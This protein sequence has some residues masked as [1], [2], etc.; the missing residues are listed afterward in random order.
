MTLWVG[1]KSPKQK[2]REAGIISY[3]GRY[4]LMWVNF[5][6]TSIDSIAG[7]I[8]RSLSFPD[9]TKGHGFSEEIH[10][11]SLEE[12]LCRKAVGEAGE[13]AALSAIDGGSCTILRTPTMAIVL[14][15]VYC[16]CFRGMDK[17]DYVQR[18]SFLSK[19]EIATKGSKVFFDTQ[20]LPQEGELNIGALQIDSEDPD[21][22]VGRARGDLGRAISMARRFCEWGFV[23][24]AVQS[25]ASY[26]LMDGSLQTGFP[27]ESE[28]ANAIYKDA[29][30]AG[31]KLCGLSK[32]TTIFTVEGFP[33]SGFANELARKRE[34]GKWLIS[35]GKNDEWTHR[36]EVY[37][38]KLH[39][40]ADRPYRLDVF[41][42]VTKT[43]LEGLVC[44]LQSNSKYFAFP[45]Y[46]YA[47]IDAHN[48][49]RVREE[50][51][52]HIRDKILDRL[53][54]EDARKLEQVERALA[55][56][57]ILDELG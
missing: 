20:I 30:S 56:H 8:K 50:E 7:I 2:K 54:L 4:Y 41:E 43:E 52:M 21:F 16:N 17:G 11:G 55:G 27:G 37:I 25:G 9:R 15:R 47:L 48:Y 39:E 10:D 38:V 33:V 51:A 45:G 42:G 14:N 40:G 44:A 53:D 46:P 28:L 22:K 19:T 34:L 36:A 24:R 57:D 13:V 1:C 23:R 49:G 29:E 12:I 35:L 18:V 5:M 32:S 31:V 26:I 6:E 3:K